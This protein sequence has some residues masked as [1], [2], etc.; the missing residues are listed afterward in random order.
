MNASKPTRWL[1]LPVLILLLLQS[2]FAGV[3]EQTSRDGAR[4]QIQAFEEFGQ[5]FTAE[6]TR[7]ESIS[8]WVVDV[9]Q[10][11]A[12]SDFDLT[13]QLFDGVG[14][15]GSLLGTAVNS[16]L[17]NGFEG[18]LP[19][20]FTGVTLNIGSVYSSPT[21]AGNRLFVTSTRGVTLVLT[22]GREFKQIAKNELE[23]VGSCPVFVG[24]RMYVRCNSFLYC[25][26][27]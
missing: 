26:G 16:T 4:R 14:S 27:K 11:F 18:F 6:D 10:S 7:I 22:P 19:F 5:T 13:V 2:A 17:V 12:P 3:I 20:D 23:S 25:I 15:G 9:N 8:F 24:R 1:A 21:I